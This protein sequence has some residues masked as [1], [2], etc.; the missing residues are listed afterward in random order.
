[1]NKEEQKRAELE[2]REIGKQFREK[3]AAYRKTYKHVP[4]FVIDGPRVAINPDL[5]GDAKLYAERNQFIDTLRHGAVCA[6]IGVQ[7][8]K[9]SFDIFNRAHPKEIH[10]IDL[11]LNQ[12]QVKYPAEDIG[13]RVHLHEGKSWEV[14]ESFPD[15]YFDWI[16][17]DGAHNYA[18]VKKDLTQACR[19][20]K[21][22]G[23]IICNDYMTWSTSEGYPYG[24]LPAVNECVNAMNWPIRALSLHPSGNFDIAFQRPY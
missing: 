20:I 16:Y 1:M 21:K 12:M 7:F 8:G 24:V 2:L 11:R 23:Y 9:F 6:E 15:D 17:V 14:M 3:L 4:D 22:G 19:T 5:V 13:K 18:S 10:L